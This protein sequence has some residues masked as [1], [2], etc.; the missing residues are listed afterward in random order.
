MD[1]IALITQKDTL[2]TEST[3]NVEIIYSDS[4]IITAK[5]ISP[6]IDNYGGDTPYTVF[7]KGIH[8]VFYKRNLE[9]ES[10]LKAQYAIRKGNQGWMQA[11]RNVEVLNKKGERLNCEELIWEQEKKKIISNSF[12]KITTKDE[13]LKGNGLEANE[14]F[15]WYRI[16]KLTGTIKLKN[17]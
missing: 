2:P 13:I 10:E 14:D 1:T 17:E 3:K 5:I 9:V 15:T 11:K 8:L 7:P 16:K 6:Q 4:G 12:V